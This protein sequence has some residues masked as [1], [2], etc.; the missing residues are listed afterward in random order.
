MEKKKKRKKARRTVHS[1]EGA[2]I[3]ANLDVVVLH[4][5]N[6]HSVFETER[7][8]REDRQIFLLLFQNSQ[9]K[10]LSIRFVP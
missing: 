1:F 9:Y 2:C 10:R 7:L 6:K 3:V 5:Y 8:N 4:F